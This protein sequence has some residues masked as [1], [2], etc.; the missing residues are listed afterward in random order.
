MTKRTLVPV[1]VPAAW[2][3]GGC[4]LAGAAYSGNMIGLSEGL[5]ITAIIGAAAIAMVGHSGTDVGAVLRAAGDER[6]SFLDVRARGNAALLVFFFCAVQT[7]RW[8]A[9]GH[10]RLGQPYLIVCIVET[11]GYVTSL[12]W[13]TFKQNTA[14]KD[15]AT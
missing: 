11:T 13:L 4:A 2:F 7:G 5:A 3:V 12:L 8:Y 9:N 10:G 14:T 1:F 6:Q 15:A